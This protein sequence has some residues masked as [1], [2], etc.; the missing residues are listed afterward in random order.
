MNWSIVVIW[1]ILKME[2]NGTNIRVMK[3]DGNDT[4][5]VLTYLILFLCFFSAKNDIFGTIIL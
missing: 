5:V 2:D 3:Y 4:Y 1:S